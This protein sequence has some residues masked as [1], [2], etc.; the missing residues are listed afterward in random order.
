M[1]F[2]VF[3]DE[4]SFYKDCCNDINIFLIGTPHRKKTEKGYEP[5]KKKFDVFYN[6][7]AVVL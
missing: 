4:R 5:T 7:Q 2:N 3:F 1:R 6:M